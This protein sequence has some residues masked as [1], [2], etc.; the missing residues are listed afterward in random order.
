MRTKAGYLVGQGR[1]DRLEEQG[2]ERKANQK[3][4][5]A[6]VDERVRQNIEEHGA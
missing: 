1:Q 3:K 5:E 6:D 4:T 2:D